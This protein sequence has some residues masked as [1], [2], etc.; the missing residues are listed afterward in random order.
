MP[1]WKKER[2]RRDMKKSVMKRCMAAILVMA[3]VFTSAD[4]SSVITLNAGDSQGDLKITDGEL[5]ANNY[6]ELSAEEKAILRSEAISGSTYSLT[7]PTADNELTAVDSDNKVIYAKEF[8]SGEYVWYPEKAEVV[9]DKAAVETVELEKG[10]YT[11]DGESYD[12]SKAFNY[13]GD[14]YTVVVTYNVYIDVDEDVQKTYL[15]LP[16]YFA[17]AMN[18]MDAIKSATS[19]LN[20]IVKYVAPELEQYIDGSS[21]I[22]FKGRTKQIVESWLQQRAEHNQSKLAYLLS[23]DNGYNNATRKVEN[24]LTYGAEYRAEAKVVSD[25]LSYLVS[26]DAIKLALGDQVDVLNEIIEK[27]APAVNSNWDILALNASSPVLKSGLTDKQHQDFDALVKAAMGKSQTHDVEIQKTL[28]A[29]S[30]AIECNVNRYNVSV[31]VVIK[32]VDA[33][34]AVQTVKTATTTVNLAGGVTKA[35]VLAAIKANGIEDSTVSLIN[36]ENPLYAVGEEHYKRDIESTLDDT[37]TED[38]TYI[39][40]YSPK[41]YTVNYTDGELTDVTVPYG[42]EITFPLSTV[43]GQTYEYRVAGESGFYEEGAKFRVV[44]DVEVSR[45]LGKAKTPNRIYDIVVSDYELS[46]KEAAI[47]SNLAL[48]SD[49]IHIRMAEEKLVTL[50]GLEEVVAIEYDAGYGMRWVPTTVYVKNGTEVVE[51]ITSFD[52]NGKAAITA[53]DFTTVEAVYKLK[54]DITDG[55]LLEALNLPKT[56]VDDATQQL[57]DL[58]TLAGYEAELDMITG[59]LLETVSSQLNAASQAAIKEIVEQGCTTDS[60]NVL[61]LILSDYIDQ[62]KALETDVE[63]LSFYYNNDTYAT[64]KA[65]AAMV[66]RNMGVIV[67][68]P[69]LPTVLKSFNMSEYIEK[70]EGVEEKLNILLDKFPAKH[71]KINVNN[72]AFESLLAAILSKGTV[73]AH[74]TENDLYLTTTFSKTAPS[75][76]LV[77]VDVQVADGNG[78]IASSAIKSYEESFARATGMSAADIQA[79]L[80]KV[81]EFEAALTIDKAHYT[82]TVEGALPEADTALAGTVEVIYTWAPNSYTLKIDGEADQTF[83][84]DNRRITL[85]ASASAD[86]KDYYIIG[87]RRIEVTDKSVTI[88]LTAQEFDALYGAN[89]TYTVV[90]EIVDVKRERVINL[91]TSL[92][93]ELSTSGM[94]GVASFVP[95]EDAQGNISIVLRMNAFDQNI[96][97]ALEKIV[98]VLVNQSYVGL[99]GGTFKDSN[100]IYVNTVVDLLLNSGITSTA[101]NDMIDANGNIKENV[102]DQVKGQTVIVDAASGIPATDQLGGLLME[103]TFSISQSEKGMPLYISLQ[104]YDANAAELK[105]INSA[106][107]KIAPYALIEL[108]EGA[109]HAIVTAPEKAH[110]LLMAA[111]L[112]EGEVDLKDFET[113]SFVNIV[114]YLDEMG[115]GPVLKSE[116][117]TADTLLNTVAQLSAGT[118]LSGYKDALNSVLSIVRKLLDDSFENPE[119]TPVNVEGQDKDLYAVEVSCPT[120]TI[121]GAANLP[122]GI[123]NLLIG[124]INV[125]VNVRLTNCNTEYAAVVVDIKAEGIQNKVDFTTKKDIVTKNANSVVVLLNDVDSITANGKTYIDLNG[126]A[127]QTLNANAMVTVFD[128]TLSSEQAGTI[129]T[130]NG[131]NNVVLT[132]GTYAADVSGM[133]PDGYVQVDNVVSNRFYRLV[134]D[135]NE[136]ITIELAADF[137]DLQDAVAWKQLAL[138]MA[139]DVALNAYTWAGVTV[140]GAEKY[141]IYEIEILDVIA[142]YK[143]GLKPLASTLIE[144]INC[145]GI[146]AFANDLIAKLTDFAGIQNAIE[147]DTAIVEYNLITKPWDV[148]L[149]KAANA[150]YLTAN[151]LAGKETERTITIKVAGKEQ[152]KKDLA[153]LCKELG[154]IFGDTIDI[155][156]ILDDLTYDVNNGFS[157]EV[158]ADIKATADLSNKH[159]VAVIGTILAYGMSDSD[160]MVAAINKYFDE[161]VTTDL[162]A[163]IENMTAAQ[164]IASLKKANGVPFADMVTALGIDD[165]EG[166]L[167]ELQTIYEDALNI[168]YKLINVLKISGGSQKLVSLKTDEFGTYNITKESWHRMDI[169]LTLI[170]ADEVVHV[171][172]PGTPVQENVVGATCHSEGSYDE[173]VYCDVCKEEL[174]RVTKPIDMIDHTPGTAVVENYVGATC[175]SEGSYDEVV[176]CTVDECKKELSR[177]TKPIDMIDHT[178]GTPVVENYVG[179]SCTAPGSYD[180]VVYCTVD[181]CKKELSRVTKPIEMIPHSLKYVEKVPATVDTTGTEEHWVCTVC[182][183][184]FADAEGKVEVKAEDLVIP[185]LLVPDILVPTVKDSDALNAA[186]VVDK[187]IYMDVTSEEGITQE[188]LLKAIAFQATNNG[189]I[190]YKFSD[191]A[192]NLVQTGET[193]TITAT[194]ADGTDVETY[195]F[196]VLGDVDSDGQIQPNDATIILKNCV[197][198]VADT[199]DFETSEYAKLAAMINGTEGVDPGDATIVLK[200]TVGKTY[201]TW[202][203]E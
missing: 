178:P 202:I 144:E 96:T 120:S 7:V 13:V 46:A 71:E 196:I 44:G 90:R 169:D 138:E 168:C 86:Y 121:V 162:V 4:F 123:A 54:V 73:S 153:A 37:L 131:Q 35:E 25:D 30:T 113:P 62:Y 161:G 181:A 158:G 33:T 14:G 43:E 190:T 163:L 154:L 141:D 124:D 180:E 57:A 15:N 191:E 69:N 76:A 132:A 31:Q 164:M 93:S 126:N 85:P 140:S 68:D 175:H 139:V 9:V 26:Q 48:D 81:A 16:Y 6:D 127:V 3:I 20:T 40:T 137:L 146:E 53:D 88:T 133:L 108:K 166:K 99:G 42:T 165:A 107:D 17:D 97:G 192:I 28:W 143:A 59:G 29:A 61:I 128:S 109:A 136:N 100:G 32:A 1:I 115:L 51:T 75:R 39:I 111:M 155:E 101:L 67:S 95:F 65:Q 92:N 167:V 74:T 18:N 12:A 174:S 58:R 172:T 188:D 38:A 182:G 63:R 157:Y 21:I 91:I 60:E 171:H 116:D 102:K 56:L 125:P 118:D 2:R 52:A 201:T 149:E 70:L 45:T 197:G 47:L 177:V 23:R 8:K 142:A 104:D 112:V 189:V 183:K 103:T 159:Y 160:A 173:V 50:N 193:L 106:L 72:G 36:E 203:D 156:L 89:D 199:I 187:F 194:N 145:D 152:D 179:A 78:N 82:C 200:K 110:E 151:I 98:T 94:A 185:K 170:L 135:A 122:E 77:K 41:N 27:L 105:K 186:K 195:T 198:N 147:T 176:Y 79:F 130:I 34:N 66:A 134:K 148:V 5:I 19:S 49:Y 87:A 150:D 24:I 83:T 119:I 64:L 84:Y 11:Y 129:V 22:Q 117:V 80:D 10:T 55:A 184:L 114:K